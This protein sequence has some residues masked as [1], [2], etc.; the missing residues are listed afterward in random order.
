MLHWKLLRELLS[1]ELKQRAEEGCDVTG[2]AERFETAGQ[3]ADALNALYDEL[4]TLEP[5]ADFGYYEPSGLEE[6][7]AARPKQTV[8]LPSADSID[9]DRFHAALLGRCCGCA[10]GKPLEG[11]FFSHGGI[12]G[13]KWI[14]DWYAEAGQYP[15]RD[16][17]PL[18]SPVEGRDGQVLNS[19]SYESVKENISFMQSDDDI[20]YTVLGIELIRKH[21]L[22][23]GPLE[24][25]MLWQEKLPHSSVYTAERCAY[26]NLPYAQD[27]MRADGSEACKAQALD[28]VR[29]YRNP[30]REWIGAQIRVD[31]YAYAAAGNPE[32]AAELAWRDASLSHVKNGIYGAMF[33]AAAIAAAFVE[34]DPERIVQAGL[35]QIPENC[36]LAAD[37]RKAVELA[38]NASDEVELVKALWE[39]FDHYHPVHTNNNAALC[40]A[41]VIFAKGDFTKAIGTSV[42]G[43]WDTDCNGATVGSIMGAALGTAGIPEHWS[44]PLND[45]LYSEIPGYHPISIRACA[46]LSYEQH[47]AVV[48]KQI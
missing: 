28:H 22:N 43:G 23:W 7:R 17:V 5:V 27:M 12:P 14:Y 41:S 40:V 29:M 42:L 36:R 39:N 44:A 19:C 6:I 10:L 31:G 13:W 21:G 46:H 34:S 48:S 47:R 45:T 30:Y 11:A 8:F 37:L 9:E 33:C 25:G 38:K 1:E 35:E 3:D 4:M 2:F 16:Y 24:V 20:R 15:I 18:H 32:L 26:D